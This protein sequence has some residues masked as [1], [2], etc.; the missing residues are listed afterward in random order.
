MNRIG[1]IYMCSACLMFV[2]IVGYAIA[3]QD[4]LRIDVIVEEM[5]R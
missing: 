3:S 1:M 4:G 5:I 2:L